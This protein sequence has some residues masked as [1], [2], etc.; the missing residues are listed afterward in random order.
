VPWRQKMSL[1]TWVLSLCISESRECHLSCESDRKNCDNKDEISKARR[2]ILFLYSALRYTIHWKTNAIIGRR[3]VVYYGDS[4]GEYKRKSRTGKEKR[5]FGN[6]IVLIV[7]N[8]STCCSE[9]LKIRKNIYV[10]V[11]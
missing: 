6:L 2:L 7:R 5:I 3:N 1:I 8:R 10:R 11:D 4:F 9:I